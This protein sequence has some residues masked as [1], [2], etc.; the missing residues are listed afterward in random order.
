[1]IGIRLALEERVGNCSVSGRMIPFVI[2]AVFL[3]FS[4]CGGG[5]EKLSAVLIVIDG[6]RFDEVGRSTV[7]GEV[8][9]HLDDFTAGSTRFLQATA[10]APWTLPSMASMLT[11]LHP[12]V[13]GAGGSYPEFRAIRPAAITGPEILSRNG[14]RCAAFVNGPFMAPSFGMAKG[15]D[16]YD[17]EPTTV[18]RIRSAGSTLDGALQWLGIHGSERF[19]L[20]VHLVDPLM[21]FDPPE[22]Q[23]SQFLAGY[24]GSREAPFRGAR[25][26]RETELPDYSVRGF[27]RLLYR[28]ELAAVDQE[29]GRFLAGLDSLGLAQNTA[30][31][32]TADHGLEI[33]DHGSF[34][35][36]LSLFEEQIHVPLIMNVP[37]SGW[38]DTI[39][40]RVGGID[41]MPTLVDLMGL[42]LP[43]AFQGESLVPF[44]EGK[45]TRRS[46]VRFAESILHGGE[47]KSAVDDRFKLVAKID[48]MQK[49]LLD[50]LVDP[51]EKASITKTY[52]ERTA[53]LE[54]QLSIWLKE[55]LNRASALGEDGLT[56]RI[57][58]EGDT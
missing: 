49:A 39:R 51:S 53:E 32:V 41:I 34:G 17:Y 55:N 6:A 27:A 28:A 4:G 45:E 48:G 25:R 19:F 3:I 58:E 57:E 33:W 47:V 52:A 38:P 14:V 11:S 56:I 8:T 30:V 23:R 50:L 22:P 31:V 7:E 18:D 43:E 5:G 54:E 44:L 2:A 26:W 16:T 1:M 42:P 36:G 12:T 40:E 46:S 24:R 9:P 13:H 37:G 29:I 35:E 20:L 15:F 21:D 10:P